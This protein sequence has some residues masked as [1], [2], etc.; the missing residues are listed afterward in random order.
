[1]SGRRVGGKPSPEYNIALLGD[2]GV[3]KSG[4]MFHLA[5]GVVRVLG[6]F[7]RRADF[8][9]QYIF[10]NDVEIIGL[11]EVGLVKAQVI[12]ISNCLIGFSFIAIKEIAL[13]PWI[14]INEIARKLAIAPVN[15]ICEIA[16]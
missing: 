13:F 14:L 15:Q 1:M 5:I 7:L 12:C 6:T 9:L 2:L 16:F 8:C 3:G 11:P 4:E 10:V